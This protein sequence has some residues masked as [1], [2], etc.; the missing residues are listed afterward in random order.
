MGKHTA[1]TTKTGRRTFWQA[2]IPS[3][4]ALGYLV[5]EIANILVKDLDGI[6]PEH[7]RTWLIAAAG[8]IAAIAAALAKIMALPGVN[9]IL[10]RLGLDNPTTEEGSND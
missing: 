7:W 4:I 3:A 5:P 2:F 1:P 9:R 8:A 6:L 10:S